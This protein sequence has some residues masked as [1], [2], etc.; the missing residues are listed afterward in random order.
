MKVR[1]SYKLKD[2]IRLL[3]KDYE[4]KGS[5]RFKITFE[6]GTEAV[7]YQRL[8]KDYSLQVIDRDNV[9][10]PLKNNEA[11]ITLGELGI[12]RFSSL[13]VEVE[14]FT[15]ANAMASIMI[16]VDHQKYITFKNSSED[17]ELT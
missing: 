14:N 2:V 3:Q 1:K 12:N 6:D 4:L 10:F 7:S 16:R 5:E 8:T 17:G 13:K 15:A 11:E 9:D